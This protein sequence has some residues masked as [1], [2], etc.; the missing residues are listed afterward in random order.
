M[1]TIVFDLDGTLLASTRPYEELVATTFEAV[2]GRVHEEWLAAYGEAFREE[3]A[4]CTPDP[5]RRSFAAVDGCS[6]PGACTQ[7]LLEAEIAAFEP[8]PGTERDLDRLGDQYRLG[9]L[10]NGVR[11]WQLAKLQGNALLDRFDA[12][13]ASYEAGAHKPALEPYRL[14]EERLPAGGYALVGD[15]ESDVEGAER[16]GWAAVGYDGDGFAALPESLDWQ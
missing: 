6:D 9:V 7:R 3:F 10:T 4:S 16:A 12:V 1:K 14:L 11:D 5:V 13:V 15:S 2:E 8:P